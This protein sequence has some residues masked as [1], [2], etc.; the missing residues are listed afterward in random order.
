MTSSLHRLSEYEDI[1]RSI[2][3]TILTNIIL[4]GQH[5][6]PTFQEMDRCAIVMDRLA[7]FQVDECTT[8]GYGNPIGILRGS[9]PHSPAIFLVAHLDTAFEKDIDHNFTVS[10]DAIIGTGVMDNAVGLGTLV[11]LPEIIRRANLYF[12]SDIVLAATI[13]SIGRGNLRGIRHL[14]A[15]W[16]PSIRAAVCIESGELGRLNYYSDAMIRGEICCRITEDCRHTHQI[17]CNAILVINEVINQIL[18]LT[19][20]QRPRTKIVFG[21][22]SGGLKH[23]RNADD[24]TLGFEI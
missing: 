9:S 19:F 18:T 11:S 14:L 6:A 13:H 24:A 21:K 1:S 7:E 17:R 5:P 2:L 4:I 15:T 20:P 3:E 12:E 22:I 8:D 16:E 10:Q 23:G